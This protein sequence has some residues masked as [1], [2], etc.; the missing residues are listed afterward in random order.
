MNTFS[1][2]VRQRVREAGRERLADAGASR[3]ATG[4]PLGSPSHHSSRVPQ[5]LY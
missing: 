2:A 5:R 3:I 1:A 4:D